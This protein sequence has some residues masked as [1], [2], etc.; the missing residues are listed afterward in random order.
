MRPKEPERTSIHLGNV[1][2][3]NYLEEVKRDKVPRRQTRRQVYLGEVK[4]D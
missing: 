4:W 2:G 3:T 1:K